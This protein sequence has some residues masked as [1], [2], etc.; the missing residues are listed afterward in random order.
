MDKNRVLHLINGEFFAGAERVQ[1]LLAITLPNFGY[2]VGFSCLK[3]DKFASR[4]TS[5]VPLY[6]TPMG[7][8]VDLSP[9]LRIA[10]IVRSEGYSLLHTHTARA[11]L[12]GRVV[13]LMTGLPMVHHVHSY[14]AVDTE[15]RL[16]N[17]INTVIERFSLTGVKSI[18]LVSESLRQYY[19]NRGMRADILHL[20]HNGVPSRLNPR[21]WQIPP[22]GSSWV[23]GM[24]ALFRPR[25]G[26]EVLL[27]A[28]ARVRQAG[29]DVRLLAVGPFE[30]PEYEAHIQDRVAVLDLQEHIEW[31]GFTKDVDAELIRMDLLVLPSLFGE[32]LPMVILEAMAA[33][34]PVLATR[35][36]GI[37]EAIRHGIDGILVEPNDA[38]QLEQ[39]L[40]TIMSALVDVDRL[41]HSAYERQTTEFSESSM[42]QGVAAV[43]EKVLGG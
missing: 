41:R 3:P 21:T 16:R 39:A 38:N 37:P 12:I 31:V 22:Q 24:V 42:A 4:R 30:T 13:S 23:V 1:D 40:I 15:N 11:A 7:S 32:G 17:Q 33:G 8:K 43:Y 26:L 2:E 5:Q 20:V 18:I 35:V 27:D 28:M 10:R 6:E 19:L 25:K 36:E 29:F 9:A 34:V 14:V